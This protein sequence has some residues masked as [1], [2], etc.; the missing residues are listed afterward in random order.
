MK[1]S[2]SDK[3]ANKKKPTKKDLIQM[4]KNRSKRGIRIQKENFGDVNVNLWTGLEW[5][6]LGLGGFGAFIYFAIALF[7]VISYPIK[8]APQFLNILGAPF[9]PIWIVVK[10]A[11]EYNTK[12]KKGKKK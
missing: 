9:L 8:G 11:T 6:E 1:R 2:K 7:I 5:W 4:I 3:R 10:L 12:R